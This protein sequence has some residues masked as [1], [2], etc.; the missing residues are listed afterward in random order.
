MKNSD[1]HQDAVSQSV[2]LKPETKR[3]LKVTEENQLMTY[4]GSQ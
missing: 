4:E 2:N 3:T 1:L